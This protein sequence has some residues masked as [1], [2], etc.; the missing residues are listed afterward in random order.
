MSE[1][2]SAA[3]R[4]GVLCP[5]FALRTGE[6]LGIGDTEAVRGLIDWAAE[7]GLGFVQFLPIN[8]TG[9]DNSPYNA[10]SSVALEPLTLDVSPAAVPELAPEEFTGVCARHQV[11]SWPGEVVDYPAVRAL[12]SELLDLA[13]RR[14]V[15]GRV[16]G[17]GLDD[18]RA[19]LASFRVAEAEWLDEF[20][21]FSVLMERAG[22][23]D[24]PNWPEEFNTAEKAWAW[25]EAE[26]AARPEAVEQEL[27]R[28]AY[29]QWLCAGQWEAVRAHAAAR[30][31][32]MM[33]DVPFGVSWCSADV[34]FHPEE[35]DLDWCGGAPPERY[36]KD[37]PFVRK[38]GQNWGIPLYDWDRM[39]AGGFRW[40]G[41]RLRKL[42][43]VFSI[44]RIDHVLG[45]YRIYGFPWRPVA[46]D[47]FLPLSGEEAAARCG[48]RRPQFLRHDDA[49]AENRAAN[50]E[51]GDRL[52]RLI[53]EAA[54]GAEVVAE[55]LGTVPEYVR[56]H[57]AS[58]D[59]PGF[60]ICQWEDDGHGHAVQGAAYPECS[61]ATFGTHDHEP[62]RTLWERLRGEVEAED[63]A[64]REAAA[65]QLKFLC[66]FGWL[67]P[68]LG[69]YPPFDDGIRRALLAA[70]FHSRSRFAAFTL[71]D[72]FG[73]EIRFNVPGVAADHNWSARLPM[74]LAEMQAESPW[75]E[76]CAWLAA[77]LRESGRAPT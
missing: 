40:W 12:K 60:R 44:F 38:W 6:D 47:D 30:G 2:L 37:D 52:L 75:R 8:A 68:E 57:L 24:W 65:R 14:L 43:A 59:I 18:R 49:T 54:P 70:L 9:R 16:A 56:P 19:A 39:A 20:C 76:E 28:V 36:F 4:A 35:F 22:G 32:A 69:P 25:L 26:R 21:L 41:R 58:L 55:D 62:L 74:T 50:L 64:T 46:N 51:Q 67:H 1:T 31:V 7:T 33:G 77:V 27:S 66:Q 72:L 63:E 23:E 42:T 71:P 73:A 53:L 17:D 3:R 11:A 13:H 10:I 5:V 15:G 48:G 34:F 45:F 61:F 29:A